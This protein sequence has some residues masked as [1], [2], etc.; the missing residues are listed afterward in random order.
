MRSSG[1]RFEFPR[2]RSLGGFPAQEEFELICK[3]KNIVEK[4]AKVDRLTDE[5]PYDETGTRR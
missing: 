1:F 5:Q 4:L 3:E 2:S